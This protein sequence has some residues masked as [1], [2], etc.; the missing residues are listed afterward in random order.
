MRKQ[1]EWCDKTRTF[2]LSADQLI[3]NDD[4][5]KLIFRLRYSCDLHIVKTRELMRL[6]GFSG[7]RE[8]WRK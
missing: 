3:Q 8:S 1:C 4:G 5:S 7:W 6:D 2:T